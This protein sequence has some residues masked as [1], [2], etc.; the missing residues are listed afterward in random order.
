MKIVAYHFWD[1]HLERG[2]G[3]ITEAMQNKSCCF[4]RE[5]HNQP[6]CDNHIPELTLSQVEFDA[7]LF[8]SCPFFLVALHNGIEPLDPLVAFL[9]RAAAC[10]GWHLWRHTA[11][12]HWTWGCG[13]WALA[14]LCNLLGTWDA[15]VP[16]LGC[17]GAAACTEAQSRRHCLCIVRG[18]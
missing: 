10:K 1:P 14:G 3:N 17:C 5:A 4:N 16:L 11:R 9:L 7:F 2:D 6:L 8:A 13:C 18:S 15:G 12:C